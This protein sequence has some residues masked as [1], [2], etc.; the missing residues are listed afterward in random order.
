AT[1][2]GAPAEVCVVARSRSR[3]TTRPPGPDPVT[4][5][6]STPASLAMRLA[7]GE[8]LTRAT[9]AGAG[10]TATPPPSRVPLLASRIPLPEGAG[11]GGGAEVT[12]APTVSPDAA[13]TATTF[14]TGTVCPSA[15]A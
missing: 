4:S 5:L 11:A 7:S 1:A 6:R 10:A 15:T 12:D 8:A 3:L 13:M 9:S 2:A 14:P